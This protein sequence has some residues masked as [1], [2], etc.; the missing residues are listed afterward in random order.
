MKYDWAGKLIY[1]ELCKWLK[2]DH[3][4]QWYLHKPEPVLENMANEILLDFEI[5]TD[6]AISARRS[7]L[8]KKLINSLILLFQ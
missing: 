7:D 2:N 8:K 1:W 5:R 4:E 6:H 3:V